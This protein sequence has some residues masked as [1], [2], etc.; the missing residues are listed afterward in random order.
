MC[1]STQVDPTRDRAVTFADIERAH[2]RLHGVAHRT[3][4]ARSRTLDSLSGCQVRLKC[5][6]LQRAGAFKFRGAFNALSLHQR[7]HPGEGVLA[8][9][10]GNHA[11][12]VA[13]AG[14]LLGIPVT[15]VM[16]QDAPRVK[17]N[18]TRDY[19]A[20]IVF[21]DRDRSD[22]Q[23]VAERVA[24]ERE[25]RIVHAYDDARVIAGQG[26]AVKELIEDAGE[27]DLL[28]VCLGG[29][30]LLSGSALSARA[31]SPGC[32]VVGVE[33]ELADDAARTFR[34]GTLQ[35]VHN[36]PTIADGAR[37]PS[38]GQIT[39]PL[40]LELADDV[41]TVS[42]RAIVQAMRFCWERLKLVVE[43]T[44]A[45]ALAALL[46]RVVQPEPGA[47]V[48]VT[49]S[50]GNVDLDRAAALFATR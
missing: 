33:P 45:L 19:G 10:S 5:E 21:Y 44:G 16:P 28:L 40:V 25:L 41:V 30:G 17:A 13:L 34:T 20:E 9:S 18:A 29:G 31:L 2:E 11:Q 50:G 15:V 23:T 7:R 48:G 32:R 22:R 27:L 26:T 39:M 38:L 6:S 36:P 24:A 42:E 46:D 47:R 12:A 43:P 14:Q 4:V 3:P 35:S 8:A 49:L 1:P 37:T